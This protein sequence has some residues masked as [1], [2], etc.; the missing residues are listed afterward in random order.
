[1]D[2]TDHKEADHNEEDLK[3]E[4]HEG[5]DHT[6]ASH[7]EAN[8]KEADHNEANHNHEE[9]NHK[10]V[11]ILVVGSNSEQKRG[12]VE[13]LTRCGEWD[14]CKTVGVRILTCKSR[15]RIVVDTTLLVDVPGKS[16][17]AIARRWISRNALRRILID[18]LVVVVCVFTCAVRNT[19]RYEMFSYSYCWVDVFGLIFQDHK[20]AVI[21]LVNTE[22][23]VDVIPESTKTELERFVQ[24]HELPAKNIIYSNLTDGDDTF[25][26]VVD[27]SIQSNR[28]ISH[29]GNL[30]RAI[31]FWPSVSRRHTEDMQNRSPRASLHPPVI[32]LPVAVSS[33]KEMFGPWGPERVILFGRTGSG[34]STLAQ[35]L[36][37]GDLDPHNK[38]FMSSSGIRG[39]TSEIEHGEGRGWYVLDTP[40]F[41][42]P[43]GA[44]STISTQEAERKIKKYVKMLEGTF[45]HYVYVVRAARLDQLEERLWKFF[46]K[47]FGEE[48]KQHFSVVVSEADEEW[49]QNNLPEL[50]ACF[51][52]CE[53]FLSAEFPPIDKT[54]QD[55]EDLYQ[56]IRKESLQKLEENLS[57]LNRVDMHCSYGK[58]SK[59]HVRN[60]RDRANRDMGMEKDLRI[61]FLNHG[62][63]ACF[64]VSSLISLLTTP[65]SELTSLLTVDDNIAL[66]PG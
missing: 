32:P 33:E 28:K 48:I 24:Y 40:G 15:D 55:M 62:A 46:L 2:D 59:M 44:A 11:V 57:E 18:R 49:V 1:M 39:G 27:E 60:E 29:D 21:M 51:I 56:G 13:S 23:I 12:V 26:K 45:S 53:S 61:R 63:Q 22:G 16:P 47:L 14:E 20:E 36:T 58:N 30:L 54:D 38:K 64:A 8:H 3:E 50:R 17:S 19:C 43:K 66:L 4:D 65:I 35:M 5:A 10:E 37:L 9:V 41:G 31:S 52:G 42:E 6:D 7:K 25:S 34:K